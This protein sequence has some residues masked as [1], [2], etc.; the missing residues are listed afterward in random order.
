MRDLI[1]SAGAYIA[2]IASENASE[3][4]KNALTPKT[5]WSAVH[6]CRGGTRDV[7]PLRTLLSACLTCVGAD[8]R[9]S[10]AEHR[11]ESMSLDKVASAGTTRPRAAQLG[12]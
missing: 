12:R 7:C 1:T 5:G 6:G 9:R 10:F 2:V 4:Y 11:R 8:T 3:A